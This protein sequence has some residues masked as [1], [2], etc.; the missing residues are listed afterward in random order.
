MENPTQDECFK[1][2]A[3]HSVPVLC[4]LTIERQC[5]YCS[6]SSLRVLGWEPEEMLAYFPKDLIHSGDELSARLSHERQVSEEGQDDTPGMMRVRKKDGNYTWLEVTSSLMRNQMTQAPWQ[7][8]L[9]M[10]DV[11]QR[12]LRDEQLEALAM[13]DSLTGLG[14][15]R[16]FNEVLEREWARARRGNSEVSLLMLDVDNFKGVNDRFGHDV[17]DD[18]LRAIGHT[19]ATVGKR[20]GDMAARYGGEEF[21]LIL[22]ETDAEGAA[23]VAER[24]RKAIKRLDLPHGRNAEHDSVVTV[25]VGAVTVVFNAGGKPVTPGNLLK[26]ADTALYKAKQQGRNR[27]ETSLLV[28]STR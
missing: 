19:I 18:C 21:A 5:T 20:A 10:R 2:M 8:L 12:R 14:N 17:G 15:R 24:L 3:E 25:S 6:P 13:T 28:G 7:V 1:M 16:A 4:C 9:N 26:A 22:P 27:V 11:S 23:E